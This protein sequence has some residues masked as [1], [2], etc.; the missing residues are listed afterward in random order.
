[1]YRPAVAP[2][3]ANAGDDG[4]IMATATVDVAV[5]SESKKDLRA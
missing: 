5:T 2:P 4:I 1:M 3:L